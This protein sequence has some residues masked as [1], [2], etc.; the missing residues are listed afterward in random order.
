MPDVLNAAIPRRVRVFKD[1]YANLPTTDLLPE[2]L[3]YATDRSTLYRWSGAA[4]EALSFPSLTGLD[5]A[6]P[7]AADLPNG[8]LYTTTDTHL[9][10][11]VQSGAWVVIS[12]VTAAAIAG[13]YIEIYVNNGVHTTQATYTKIREIKLGRSGSFR[14]YFVMKSLSGVYP[15]YGQIYRNGVAV[16]TERTTSSTSYVGFTEDISGWNVGDLLQIYGH[17]NGS[18]EC[19][20]QD[21]TLA[22]TAPVIG[23]RSGSY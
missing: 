13:E 9:V 14:I 19:Y 1:T 6:K 10:Y 22:V 23:G 3:G 16:G 20:I 12:N 5:A 18:E 15:V 21:T 7:S 2:D 8:S 11:E 17:S 4:W